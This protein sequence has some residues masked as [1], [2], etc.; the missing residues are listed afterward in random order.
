MGKISIIV[1]VYNSQNTLR[2]CIES[3]MAQDESVCEILL[4]NDGSTDN[5]LKICKEYEAK[6][7]RI[8]VIDKKNQGVSEA[9]NTGLLYARGEYIQFVDSDDFVE[10]DMCKVLLQEMEKGDADLCICGFH[11]LFAGR[12]VVKKCGEYVC[13][14][15]YGE[16]ANQFILLY[17]QGFLN[18]PWNKLYKKELIT[19]YFDTDLSL[20]EDLIFN[21]SYLENIKEKS[22]HPLIVTIPETLYFYVQNPMEKTLSSG[23]G[24]NKLALSAFLC[25]TTVK[26]Y[27]DVLERRGQEREIQERMV[28]EAMCELAESVLKKKFHW[29]DFQALAGEYY[30][31]SYLHKI[32]TSMEGLPLDL[33]VLN[34]FFIRK[35]FRTM[36]FLCKIR[37][38][39]VQIKRA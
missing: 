7:S 14:M 28:A 38:V 12:D 20:G 26:F 15:E 1:P 8:H 35:K 10:P 27:N 25:N 36:W 11:H 29:R 16:F 13:T 19:D 18:M 3:M 33:K 23:A 5:S 34:Y 2:R 24:H 39:L 31:D 6:D 32:N 17:Q 4:I 9:R 22:E 30:N 21:L 37:K